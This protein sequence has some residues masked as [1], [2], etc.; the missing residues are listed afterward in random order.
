MNDDH[1]ATRQAAHDVTGIAYRLAVIASVITALVLASVNRSGQIEHEERLD[2]LEE[3]SKIINNLE[4]STAELNSLRISRPARAAD[5][6]S[7]SVTADQVADNGEPGDC[8]T[9]KDGLNPTTNTTAGQ[10]RT[11]TVT[12]AKNTEVAKNDR[13]STNPERKHSATQNPTPPPKEVQR[14]FRSVDEKA[15]KDGGR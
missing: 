6:E 3:T 15:P 9:A 13:T 14:T 11:P 7:V 1:G 5:T 2:R 12:T 10:P 4:G 8:A